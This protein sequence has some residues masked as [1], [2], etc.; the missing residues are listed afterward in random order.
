M[1]IYVLTMHLPAAADQLVAWA[2]VF[3]H[4]GIIPHLEQ[5]VIALLSIPVRRIWQDLLDK[6]PG[7]PNL[8]LEEIE[9]LMD[10]FHMD[11][12]SRR[13]RTISKSVHRHEQ[14]SESLDDVP[15]DLRTLRDGTPFL[16]FSGAGLY[17]Y[18]ST[19]TIEKAA[20]NGLMALRIQVRGWITRRIQ[21]AQKTLNH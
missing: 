18:Y 5:R 8:S 3:F 17:V 6:I 10:E 12:F 21:M 7:M 14:P 16:Q 19:K 1:T 15:E 4:G 20:A 11:G 9:E 13:R 2:D